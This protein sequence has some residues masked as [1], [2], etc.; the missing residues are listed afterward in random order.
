MG[1]N[2]TTD[3]GSLAITLKLGP[4]VNR[5][6]PPALPSLQ[7]PE[8]VL[9]TSLEAHPLQAIAGHRANPC[10]HHSRGG[11][12]RRMKNEVHSMETPSCAPVTE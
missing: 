5:Y 1:Y 3:D 10:T 9:G 11:H 7:L 2:P 6:M 8:P 4:D 12:Q